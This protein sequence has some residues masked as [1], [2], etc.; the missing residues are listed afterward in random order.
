MDTGFRTRGEI[1]HQEWLD[2]RSRM[3]ALIDRKKRFGDQMS[4]AELKGWS[5]EAIALLEE[6]VE[7]VRKGLPEL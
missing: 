1:R 7:W 5:D 2:L 3:D 6:L 4:P